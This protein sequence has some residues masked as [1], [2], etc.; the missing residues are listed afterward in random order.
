LKAAEMTCGRA[1]GAGR[2]EQE[3]VERIVH[4]VIMAE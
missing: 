4:T 2:L 3:R 1:A